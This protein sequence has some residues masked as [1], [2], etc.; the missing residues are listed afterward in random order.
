MTPLF[1]SF[2]VFILVLNLLGL[3]P[4]FYTAT[5]NVSVTGALAAVT[6]GFMIVGAMFRYGP[7]GFVRGF[8]PHGVPWP[9]LIVLV[10]IEIFGLFVKAFALTIRLFANELAGHLVGFFLLGLIVIFGMKALPAMLMGLGIF[11]LEV[12][13]AFLQAYIFTLLSAIFISQR[14]H[15]EH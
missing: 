13:V 14:F 4:C 10:P 6:L 12:F 9:V 15:P 7:I 8:I 1:C 11:L 5:A 2:F 3:V